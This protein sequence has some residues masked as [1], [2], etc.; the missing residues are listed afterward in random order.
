MASYANSG[1]IEE[2][3][4]H[5]HGIKVKDTG[6]KSGMLYHSLVEI[7]SPRRKLQQFAD[8]EESP[9]NLTFSQY[10]VH[11]RYTRYTLSRKATVKPR[12][13]SIPPIKIL[14]EEPITGYEQGSVY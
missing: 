3:P 13:H 5:P 4:A 2:Y 7:N 11:I 9:S 6:Y 8:E 10:T 12:P 14:S 1:I